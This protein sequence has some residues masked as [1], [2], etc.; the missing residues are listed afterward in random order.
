MAP[1]MKDV[2]RRADVSTATVSRVLTGSSNVS[3]ALRR[4]VEAAIK[5]LNY[6]PSRVARSLRTRTSR[7]FGVIVSDIRNPFFTSLVRGIEDVAHEHEHSLILCNSDEDPG[8]EEL[9]IHVL[10]AEKVAGA[11]VVPI[12][13]DTTA[14]KILVDNGIPVVAVDRR[15]EE[16]DVDTVLLDN[17]QGACKAVSHLIE[18]GCTRIGLIGGPLHTTTGR[19]R[20]EGYK[21]ALREHGIE[22]DGDLVKIGDYK[23]VSGYSLAA[24]LLQLTSPPT[25]IFAANNMMTLGALQAIHDAGLSIPQD[26]ALVGFGDMPWATVLDPALTAVAQPTHELGSTAV[27]VLLRRIANPQQD[28]VRIRLEPELMVRQSCG[29]EPGARQQMAPMEAVATA[30]P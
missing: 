1:T 30:P 22:Q 21:R 6:K 29:C 23:Q 20:L 2:A 11:I 13:E 17:V 5:E 19:E 9:Y 3:P 24:Q 15:M 25:A 4:R 28:T 16:L 18:Q 14:C 8:K 10:M 26:I 27:R 12:R 7:I